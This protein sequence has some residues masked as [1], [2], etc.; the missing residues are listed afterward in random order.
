MR[1]RERE[2]LDRKEIEKIK[3]QV[4]EQVKLKVKDVGHI[5]VYADD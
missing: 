1:I 2:K 3:Q 4:R 5:F